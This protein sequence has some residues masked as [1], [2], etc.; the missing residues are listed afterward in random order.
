MKKCSTCRFGQKPEFADSVCV[1]CHHK[2]LWQK[3]KAEFAL[4]IE[5]GNFYFDPITKPKFEIE[6][7]EKK[8]K[9]S[10]PPEINEVKKLIEEGWTIEDI[11]E[12]I[13]VPPETIADYHKIWAKENKSL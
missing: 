2:N 4:V 11:Q 13:G 7:Q 5:G 10:L 9:I 6:I 8:A 3:V 12:L 1:Y